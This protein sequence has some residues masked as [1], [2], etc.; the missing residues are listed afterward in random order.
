MEGLFNFTLSSIATKTIKLNG[1]I[2]IG[3]PFRITGAASD[4]GILSEINNRPA[5][6]LYRHYLEEKFDLFLQN[7]LFAF[8][9]L[10]IY[11]NGTLRIV[12]VLNALEDGSLV[13]VG[14]LK[15]G[16]KGSLVLLNTPLLLKSLERDLST[17]RQQPSKG[18]MFLIN[19]LIRKKILKK[20]AQ[21]EIEHIQNIIGPDCPTIGIYTD[22]SVFS[23]DENREVSLE[24]GT[25]L[26]SLWS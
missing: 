6:D 4:R 24:A 18:V 14:Q 3:K 25:M 21:K 20:D 11:D 1:F 8:Y 17:L 22:Y 7:N 13:C 19:S 26:A 5:I 10:G 23:N 15:H 9:P 2:P 16:A 12:T